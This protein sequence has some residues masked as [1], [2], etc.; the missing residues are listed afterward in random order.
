MRFGDPW[1]GN[2]AD[3]PNPKLKKNTTGVTNHD[4]F[5]EHGEILK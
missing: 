1:K 2:I 5:S 3:P 4:L